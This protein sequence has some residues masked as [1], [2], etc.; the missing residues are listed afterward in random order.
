L[1]GRA[2]ELAML[3]DFCTAAN[4]SPYLYLS[5]PAWVGKSALLSWFVLHPPPG[6]RIVSFFVTARFAGSSYRVAFVDV[7]M[8][9]LVE[10]LGQPMPVFLTEATQEAHLLGMLAQAATACERQGKRLVLVV[11]G[12]DEDRALATGPDVRSIASLLPIDP[13]ANMRIVVS[14][15]L[16]PPL[17]S[18][19]AEQH[20]L[21][22]AS[23]TRLLSPGP[24]SRAS[25][26]A[27]RRE[28]NRLLTRTSTEL[29]LLGLLSAAGWP[30]A[31]RDLVELTGMSEQQVKGRL[32]SMDGRV[33]VRDP[34]RSKERRGFYSIAD[35]E[36]RQESVKLLGSVRIQVYIDLL[37][38]WAENYRLRGWPANTPSYLLEGYFG[39]LQATNDVSRMTILATD[40]QRHRCMRRLAD[41]D[42]AVV[43]EI[44][45][46]IVALFQENE[47]DAELAERLL[48]NFDRA[49]AIARGLASSHERARALTK[50]A[51]AAVAAG[52]ADQAE[53]LVLAVPEA[54]RRAQIR[55]GYTQADPRT[56]QATEPLSAKTT[57]ATAGARAVVGTR[58]RF[59]QEMAPCGRQVDG[60]HYRDRDD[61]GFVIYDQFYACGCRRTRHEYHDGS[62]RQTSVRHDGK[63]LLDDP[64]PELDD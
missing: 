18:D 3:A 60:E 14:G 54:S 5:A 8:E 52:M 55:A 61:D 49:A 4:G 46:A 16:N 41:G 10:L 45:S 34:T 31:T 36:L 62:I 39:L 50:L 48:E 58:D 22:D 7:L 42:T 30:L 64:G 11:D 29:E 57:A 28:L 12:L 35:D 20:P 44:S 33:V 24:H 17:P 38:S 51:R 25:R 9:Q 53:E 2:G 37:H 59:I 63:V 26:S 32:S 40:Q 1:I 19:V 23:N 21:R 15:R 13:P 27:I 47:P 6:L 43:T 56:G